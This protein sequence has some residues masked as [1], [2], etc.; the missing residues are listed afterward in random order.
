MLAALLLPLAVPPSSQA[1][2]TGVDPELEEWTV[3]YEA[4]RP[5]DPYVAPDG[6]VWFVGQ[7]SDYVAVM[8]P[9]TGDFRKYDLEDGAGPHNLVV[10]DDGTVW[11]AGNRASHIGRVDAATGEITKYMMPDERARDPHTLEIAPDGTLWF[12][13]QGGNMIG[14]FDPATGRTRLVEAPEV[15]GGRST[16]SRPYGI[17]MDSRGNPWVVLFNTNKIARVD[18]ATMELTIHEL[19]EDAR[20]RR[21]V[22]DSKDQVWYVDYAQ[23]RLG[24]LD[25][26]TGSVEEWDAPGGRESRPYGMAIDEW[27]RVWF[28]ETGMSPNTFVGFDPATESFTSVSPIGSG[29]GAVRHMYYDADTDAIWFGTDANTVGRA[30]VPAPR[31]GVS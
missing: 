24:R 1:Q 30:V 14:H 13:V 18:P 10:A 12:T 2:T 4:S 27:D 6:R 23:G 15:P 3:P 11:Y 29:A 25:P 17:K 9:S 22:V 5:R 31:R 8:D 16:S 28:V 26:A 19:P 20:P 21:L 7:R